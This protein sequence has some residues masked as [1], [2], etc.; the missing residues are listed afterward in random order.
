MSMDS[1]IRALAT[2]IAT[3][4]NTLTLRIG[5]KT[6]LV[7]SATGQITWVFAIPY[8]TGKIPVV[9]GL[10]ETTNPRSHVVNIVSVSNT[11]AVISVTRSKLVSIA[12]L[13]VAVDAF[14]PAPTTTVHLTASLP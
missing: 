5:Q 10:V 6:R 11:Q 2:R 14:E 12:V 8:A 1:G 3:Q 4:F 9:E 13:G 7:T